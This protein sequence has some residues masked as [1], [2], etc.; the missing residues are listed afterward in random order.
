VGEGSTL[1]ALRMGKTRSVA[2][3]LK[4]LEAASLLGRPGAET[5]G[6]KAKSVA[7]VVVSG[8]DDSSGTGDTVEKLKRPWSCMGAPAL[9]F[10]WGD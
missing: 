7:F 5:D 6:G 3:G 4:A 1:I 9:G 8:V 10:C 2:E